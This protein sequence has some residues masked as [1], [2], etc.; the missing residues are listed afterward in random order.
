MR[1]SVFSC[2]MIR[3]SLICLTLITITTGWCVDE[4]WLF[5]RYQAG[6][7]DTIRA[8][9]DR[10]PDTTA[11]RLFFKGVF[12]T[13]GEAARY[14]YD[15]ILALYPGSSIESWALERLW[16]YHWSKG[17]VAQAERFYK[18]LRQRHPDHVSA[19][20]KPD[21]SAGKNI[22]ALLVDNAAPKIIEQAVQSGP[23][24]VQIGAFSKPESA[25][26]IARKVM[27]FG[28]VDLVNKNVKGKVLTI[29]MVG[30]LPSRMDAEKLA[31][32]IKSETGLKGIAVSVEDN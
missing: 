18:F 1:Q 27:Q 12:E 23:W 14:Y 13:D 32:K 25:R 3:I 10:I 2:D 8:M 5:E 21:F 16:Q 28:T 26:K 20:K 11:A 29:V 24:R 7:M 22:A 30:R 31:E 15:R 6:D 4:T 9:L 19:V 17:D